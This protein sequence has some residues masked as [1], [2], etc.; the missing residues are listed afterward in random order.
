MRFLLIFFT[1]LLTKWRELW[2]LKDG[3]ETPH[4]MEKSR[5]PIRNT[6]IRLS[7][8][9]RI[10][11][12]VKTTNCRGL[13]VTAASMMLANPNAAALTVF[14]GRMG[15]RLEAVRATAWEKPA[16]TNRWLRK[17]DLES[18]RFTTTSLEPLGKVHPPS[19]LFPPL[20]PTHSL[21]FKQVW[22]GFPVTQKIPEPEHPEW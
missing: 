8:E 11:S 2:A 22:P 15:C 5:S 18:T 7:C 16:R 3:E 10:N 9:R 14:A 21:L 19:E 13:F 1:L 20:P 17:L 6:S 12:Y 4:S